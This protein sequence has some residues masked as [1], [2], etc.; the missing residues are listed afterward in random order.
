MNEVNRT[1]D[2]IDWCCKYELC[3]FG[4]CTLDKKRRGYYNGEDGN[5]HRSSVFGN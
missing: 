3:A 1:E 2:F 5:R 4:N